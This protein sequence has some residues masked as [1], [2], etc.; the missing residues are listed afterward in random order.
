MFSTVFNAVLYRPLYNIFIG[1]I[2]AFPWIDAGIVVI[3]FTIF[4]K[5]VL[6]PLSQKSVRGQ[7]EMRKI[8]P[9]IDE[10]KTKYKDNKQEQ[11]LKTMNLYKERGI[12]PFSGIFLAL[13]QLPILIALYMVFYK[14]G[15]DV[16]HTETLYSFIKAPGEINK[17][18]LGMFDI[19]QKNTILAIVVA[20]GQYLQI[21]FTLPAMKKV[22]NDKAAPSFQNELAKSMNMQMKYVMPIFMF[23]I[24]RSFAAIVSLYLITSSVFA[25]GQEL[26]LRK[27]LAK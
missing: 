25:I 21:K 11:A 16:I 14:G 22:E 13:I 4:I 8:Q 12:N 18:F 20:L 27:K 26:Y 24:A 10:I 1:F 7:I 2:E 6:F 17:V 23:F 9:E 5:L 15:L 3:L 19:T